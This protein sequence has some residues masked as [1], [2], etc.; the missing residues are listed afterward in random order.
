MGLAVNK[1]FLPVGGRTMFCWSLLVADRL[2]EVTRLVLVTAEGDRLAA[3]QTLAA[4]IPQ[5][6]VQIVTGGSTRHGSEWNAIRSLDSAIN[7]GDIDIVVVHDAARPLASAT[8]FADVI[9]AATAVGGAI[10]VR[11]QSALVSV[12]GS[13]AAAGRDVVTVQTPQAFRAGPLLAAYQRADSS[14]FVGTD[15]SSCFEA[16]CDLPVRCVTAPADNLKITFAADLELAG[17]LLAN[18]Q[19]VR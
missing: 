3:E 5:L 9:A 7:G 8:V 19:D 17:H 10:P 14:G 1:V 11:P 6:D 2:P 4:E 12:D 13:P 16:F 15:T 18:A